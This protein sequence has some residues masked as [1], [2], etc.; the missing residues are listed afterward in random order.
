MSFEQD[1]NVRVQPD[2]HEHAEGMDGPNVQDGNE[3]VPVRY[4][5]AFKLQVATRNSQEARSWW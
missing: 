1:G 2:V 4:A 5:V 3:R